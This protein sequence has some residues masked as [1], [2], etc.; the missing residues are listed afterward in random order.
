MT[1]GLGA[2]AYSRG[3]R[4]GLVWTTRPA[5]GRRDTVKQG[6]VPVQVGAP[7]PRDS[8]ISNNHAHFTEWQVLEN[9]EIVTKQKVI[10]RRL[11]YCLLISNIMHLSQWLHQRR[12]SLH[13]PPHTLPWVWVT[14]HLR[15]GCRGRSPGARTLYS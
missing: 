8:C 14:P 13:V 9:L 5:K 7:C 6:A 12:Q 15:D 4:T 1:A 11:F 3:R 2:R 10:R